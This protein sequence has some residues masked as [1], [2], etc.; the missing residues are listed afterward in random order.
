MEA[1]RGSDGN[2]TRSD[3]LIRSTAQVTSGK[4]YR[5]PCSEEP[6]ETIFPAHLVSIDFGM[7]NSLFARVHRGPR[8]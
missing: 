5:E 1:T 8:R 7:R 3:S 2:A 4:A 6:A